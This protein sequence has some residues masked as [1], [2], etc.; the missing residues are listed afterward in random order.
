VF[1]VLA[2]R[3]DLQNGGSMREQTG[4]FA[5]LAILGL[6]IG[7]ILFNLGVVAVIAVIAFHFIHKFW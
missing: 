2:V 7:G 3:G 1:A 4:F 5:P 6:W